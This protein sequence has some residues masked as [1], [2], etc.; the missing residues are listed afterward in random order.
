MEA[1]SPVTWLKVKLALQKAWAWCKKNWKLFVGASIPFLIW[2]LTRNSDKLQEILQRTREDHQREVDILE[3]S[4]RIENQK[5]AAARVKY[6]SRLREAREAAAAAQ[7]ELDKKKKKRMEEI[8]KEHGD[9]P[10]EITRQL[11]E[12]TGIPIH[13]R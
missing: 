11:S 6:E 3:E 5:T 13:V 12:L 9:D 1:R 10:D 8:I 4:H 2:L 7:V